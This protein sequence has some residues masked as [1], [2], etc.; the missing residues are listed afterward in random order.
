MKKIILFEN[1]PERQRLYLKYSENGQNDLDT[2]Q[3]LTKYDDQHDALISKNDFEFLSDFDLIIFHRSYLVEFK[4]GSKLTPIYSF[5]KE[6]SKDLVLFTGGVNGSTY[7]QENNFK[8]QSL[9]IS[10]KEFY[11]NIL[12]FLNAYIESDTRKC[13][14]ELKYGS[15]WKIEYMLQLREL[16]TIKTF[17]VANEFNAN[18]QIEN[19]IKILGYN[20]YQASIEELLNLLNA[21]IKTI[22][23]NS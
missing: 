22:L 8:F 18:S 15:K 19:L 10:A 16:L 1:R 7:Y 5:C 20:N 2:F 3:S 23:H 12:D 9:T 14:L 6:N 21:E 17:D 13:L 11:L 4:N